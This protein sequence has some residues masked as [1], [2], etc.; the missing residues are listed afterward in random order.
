MRLRPHAAYFIAVSLLLTAALPGKAFCAGNLKGSVVNGIWIQPAKG[1]DAAPLWGF[2]EGVRI[3]IYYGPRG[4]I[5]IFTP[6]MGSKEPYVFNF[7]AIEPIPS[8]HYHRGYSELEY[9][10]KDN[11]PG[12]SLWSANSPSDSVPAAPY[13]P[14]SG[15]IGQQDGHQTLSVYIYCEEFD[16]GAKVYLGIRFRSDRPY[17]FEVSTFTQQGS[18]PLDNCIVTATMGN[19]ARLRTLYLSDGQKLSTEIWP[20]YT[21]ANFTAHD[22]TPVRSLIGDGRGGRYFIAAPNEKKPWK[23][24][25][26]PG[27]QAHWRYKGTKIAT[28]YWCVKDPDPELVGCVNGR[29]CYWASQAPIPGGISFENFEL[30]EPYREGRS[31][32]FGIAPVAPQKFIDQI[33]KRPRK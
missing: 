2:K 15:V 14:A 25:M 4:L 22:F 9:S 24:S 1:A 29:Y 30:I 11:K 13:I 7:L 10:K 16:N 5:S 32:V 17:E 31:F 6:Y 20:D 18:A 23:A 21:E 26:Y 12:K 28:Q 19:H 8:G 33:A 3:G 27:T